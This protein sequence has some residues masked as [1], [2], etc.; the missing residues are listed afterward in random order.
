MK[1]SREDQAQAEIDLEEPHNRKKLNL[2]ILDGL[3]HAASST[4]KNNFKELLIAYKSSKHP[5]LQTLEPHSEVYKPNP[6]KKKKPIELYLDTVNTLY[7]KKDLD[8]LISPLTV[9]SVFERWAPREI[10][11]F[12]LAIVRFGKQFEFIS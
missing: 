10:A 7:K 3:R 2:N 12:E 5:I 4:D 8:L 1:R 9:I 6:D 11:I